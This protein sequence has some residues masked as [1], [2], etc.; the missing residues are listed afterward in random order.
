LKHWKKR[1]ADELTNI[2]MPGRKAGS[3]KSPNATVSAK[4][5]TQLKEARAEIV[6][7]KEELNQAPKVDTSLLKELT[8]EREELKR[9]VD[10]LMADKATLL[11]NIKSEVGT[12]DEVQRLQEEVTSLNSAAEDTEEE[13]ART[14]DEVADLNHRLA[15]TAQDNDRLTRENKRLKDRLSALEQYVYVTLAPV[16]SA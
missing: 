15:Y 12:I 13:L 2:P 3:K 11:E 14:R 7:L 5:S 8:S 6:R 10:A 4:I 16:E 9:Q 1:H